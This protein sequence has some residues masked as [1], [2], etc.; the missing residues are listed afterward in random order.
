MIRK[1]IYYK[2]FREYLGWDFENIFAYIGALIIVLATHCLKVYDNLQNYVEV[3]NTL[4]ST[5]IGAFLGALALIFSGI[6]FWGSLFDERFSADIIRYTK[7]EESIDK[8]YT[9]YLFLAFN[10]IGNI[11]ALLLVILAIN[12]SLGKVSYII[13][14]IIEVILAYWFLFIIGY[15][16]AIMRNC[17]GLIK[18]KGYN[19]NAIN[20]KTIYETANEL[21]IDI[22]LEFLYR[23]ASEKEMHDSIME[24]LNNR[25]DLMDKTDEE[26]QNLRYYFE[27]FYSI[28]DSTK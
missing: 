25:I 27:K 16:V 7:D 17:V 5:L 20:K 1:F 2:K 11:I 28:D 13:Y 12:S 18:L 14:I 22:I 24:I 15:V 4:F 19:Q 9:S 26:K 3:F 6:V 23:N 21:R 8:L 10:I